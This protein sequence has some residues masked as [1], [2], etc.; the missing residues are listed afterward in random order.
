MKVQ[1]TFLSLLIAAL[2]AAGCSSPSTE[3]LS[4][5][6]VIEEPSRTPA[7]LLDRPATVFAFSEDRCDCV[8]SE[9]C[10]GN[11]SSLG[12]VAKGDKVIGVVYSDAAA[13]NFSLLRK[14]SAPEAYELN[15]Y[16]SDGFP[17]PEIWYSVSTSQGEGTLISQLYQPLTSRISLEIVNS[18]S[19]ILGASLL[20]PSEADTWNLYGGT[21]TTMEKPVTKKIK[22]GESLTVMPQADKSGSWTPTVTVETDGGNIYPSLPEF[23]KVGEGQ[24]IA[25]TLDFSGYAKGKYTVSWQITQI[26]GGKVI[27]SGSREMNVPAGLKGGFYRVSVLT[28]NGWETL[29]VHKTLCSNASNHRSIWNDWS[30]SKALRDTMSYCVYQSD[31]TSA[32]K[33]RVKNL[34]SSFSKVQVR[35]STYGISTTKVDANTIEFTIP[36]Y[37]KHKVS[38]EFDGDRQHNLFLYGVKTDPDKPTESSASV[39]Y[40]GPGEYTVGQL[41]LT[42]G[43]TLYVDYGAKLNITEPIVASGANIT[44][45]GGGIISGEKMKHWGGGTNNSEN[46]GGVLLESGGTDNLTL[47]DVSFIDGPGWNL[48]IYRSNNVTIDNINTISW[49]LN[50]DGIDLVSCK[51]VEVRDCFLRNYDDCLTLKCRLYVVNPITDM[52]DVTISRCLIWND[53]ARGI[54]I[55]PEAGNI[56]HSG[57]IH[58]VTVNDCIFLQHKSS[59]TDDLRAAFAIGQGTD[60]CTALWSGSPAPMQISGITANNLVF[61]SIDY[62]G[63]NISIWQ[64][65]GSPKVNLNNVTFN[66]IKV[67]AANGSA[68]PAFNI[69]TK[70]STVTGLTIKNFTVGGSPVTGTGS[71]FKIDYPA[72]VS[73][74][75]Q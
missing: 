32:V 49:E 39:K 52:C 18:P 4:P 69:V 37:G 30:N 56:N 27:S 70:G 66:G 34:R 19:D 2:S 8:R 10:L 28:D 35:P 1:M 64:Y 9:G 62:T 33:F 42:A 44:I 61:D 15:L 5:Y 21:L 43:Q 13:V 16:P 71:N 22:A 46:W 57:R 29:S 41:K 59:G 38:V 6:S 17:T 63:R 14:G 72:N 23:E 24:N 7:D 3:I 40:Y 58:D 55:G 20:A 53:Y 50:G 74:K 73:Y 60:G 48:K 12:S 51:G 67:L 31:F 47:K 45:A 54:V 36:A 65:G 68:Y 26:C 11:I 25:F 75:F